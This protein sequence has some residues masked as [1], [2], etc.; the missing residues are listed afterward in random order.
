MQIKHVHLWRKVIAD[1]FSIISGFL[2]RA[3]V[4]LRARLRL[5]IGI[6]MARAV[7]GAQIENTSCVANPTV[8]H[9]CL[10]GFAL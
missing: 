7:V 6:L 9:F 8:S 4:K 3:A 5:L 2:V 1:N 10:C